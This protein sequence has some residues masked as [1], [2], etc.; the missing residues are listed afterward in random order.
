MY[1]ALSQALAKTKKPY[2]RATPAEFLFKPSKLNM[3]ANTKKN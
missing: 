2:L 1:Y 3:R